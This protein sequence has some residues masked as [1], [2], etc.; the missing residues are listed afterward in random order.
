MKLLLENRK[1]AFIIGFVL[2]CGSIMQLS[3]SEFILNSAKNADAID[4]N[5]A[6]LTPVIPSSKVEENPM[7]CLVYNESSSRLHANTEKTLDYLQKGYQSYDIDLGKVDFNNCPNI[8]LT[9]PYLKHLGTIEEIEQYV[10]NGGNLLMMSTL[11]PDSHFQA[12]YR[13]FGIVNYNGFGKTNGLVMSSNVLI[14]AE[15]QTFLNETL[16]DSSL[17]VVLDHGIEPY[18][19]STRKNPLLWKTSYGEGQFMVFNGTNLTEKVSRGLIVGMLSLLDETFIYPIF[20][21]KTF[22]I[23]DFPSP[24]AKGNNDKIYKEFNQDLKSFYQNI[25]WPNM[26][27]AAKNY[28]LV[29]TG[30][31][32][33][34]YSDNVTPPFS[35][36]AEDAS[37]YLISYGRELIQSGGEL[38]FHGHNH[39]SLTMDA[40]VAESFGYN[41]WQSTEDM[42]ETLE[43]LTSY[44]KMAFPS[45]EVTSYVPPSNVLS[46]EGRTILK[47][48]LPNLV[49][50]NSLYSED[51]TGR[52]YIQE[53]EVAED[54]VVEMP[55]ISSGY[56]RTETNQW[57]I[58]N[59]ITTH[60]VFSH[61]IHPDDVISDDRSKGGWTE[62]FDEFQVFMGDIVD[63]YPWLRSLP[64]TKA[65][66]LQ[67]ITLQSDVTF[68]ETEHEINGE[69]SNFKAPHH[70]ILRTTK[71][72]KSTSHCTFE[73]IDMNTYLII[74]E[75]TEF[76]ISLK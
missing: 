76:T 34:T 15:G 63:R 70:F 50:I 42:K 72:I 17:N 20:N 40:T 8:L 26:L 41:P 43:E 45:Y 10:S 32:I 59:A 47:E 2:L 48:A 14:G 73:K 19:Q 37:N 74:A 67:A 4:I 44:T 31:L 25:W 13:H 71:N 16:N 11:D 52:G 22:Y 39:Q 35:N 24:I 62:T 23:D 7:Y 46:T 21:A 66:Y 5:D 75:E 28:N 3:R 55:R 36:S 18:I 1:L 60:G 69:I 38:G 68:N 57:E 9:T 64:V 30:A 27:K 61:F 33:Q 12:L 29:Y 53:F 65:A 51:Y 6:I 56:Y 49:T 54:N 58:T